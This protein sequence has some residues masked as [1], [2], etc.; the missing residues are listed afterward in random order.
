MSSRT[1]QS[2]IAQLTDATDRMIGVID[3]DGTVVC[4][5]NPA[6]I[7]ERWQDAMIRLTTSPDSTVV[8]GNK[9]FN[10]LAHYN[11]F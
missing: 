2:V 1:F 10:L 3:A 8:I 5:S 4:C 11:G 6:H 7:G 9:T